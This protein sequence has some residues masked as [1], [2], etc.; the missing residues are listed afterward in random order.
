MERIKKIAIR[1]RGVIAALVTLGLFMVPAMFPTQWTVFWGWLQGIG[2]GFGLFLAA[3]FGFFSLSFVAFQNHKNS[4]IRDRE[5]Y[6]KSIERE[7]AARDHL[8]DNLTKALRA[9]M[10][11]VF[12]AS[13]ICLNRI[14]A[15]GSNDLDTGGESRATYKSLLATGRIFKMT[16]PADLGLLTDNLVQEL[17]IFYHLVDGTIASVDIA[18]DARYLI[19]QLYLV[20]QQGI[21]LAKIVDLDISSLLEKQNNLEL[22]KALLTPGPA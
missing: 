5:N 2:Q 8:R 18:E 21:E 12:I 3:L 16:A 14:T 20:K 19:D 22:S 9:E 13:L 1:F 15:S 11:T 7:D 10:F 6:Q 17:I 4:L